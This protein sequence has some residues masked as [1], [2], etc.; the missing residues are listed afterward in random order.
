[1]ADKNKTLPTLEDTEIVTGEMGRRSF[2]TKTGAVMAGSVVLVAAAGCGGDVADSDEGVS[3]TDNDS[4]T[5]DP[6]AD[7]ADADGADTAD[8]DEGTDTDSGTTDA[9]SAD[10][11]FETLDASDSDGS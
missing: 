10:T 11:D 6:A 5:T 7:E 8:A 1:M 2:L 3:D 9:V 4:G